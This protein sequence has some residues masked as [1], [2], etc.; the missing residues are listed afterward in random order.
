MFP[1]MTASS[2]RRS[3]ISCALSCFHL[4]QAAVRMVPRGH[5]AAQ[6]VMERAAPLTLC[7]DQ[8]LAKDEDDPNCA[9]R[10]F[11][12]KQSWPVALAR[13]ALRTSAVGRTHWRRTLRS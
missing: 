11:A 2:E 6:G 9:E 10:R 4:E 8:L 13:E 3:I 1:R 12:L 7:A 5:A